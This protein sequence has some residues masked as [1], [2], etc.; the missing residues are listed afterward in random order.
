MT[1]VVSRMIE[2]CAFRI[3]P[4]GSRYLL[5]KRADDEPVYPG[6]WQIV[7][8][9][10]DDGESALAGSLRELR[11]E[12]GLVPLQY[13]AV[14]HTSMFYDHRN[15]AVQILP[16]F[17]ARV[18]S[19]AAVRLSTEHSEFSWVEYAEARSRIVWP[20]QKA[21]LDMVEQVIVGGEAAAG[22][23]EIPL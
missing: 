14:P 23:S 13:W 18:S 10:L 20:A 15:D 21:G 1:R 2:V 16:L 22:F 4:E 12:T 11:E 19:E 5:L 7:T 9:A 17:A 8:G 6:M 3:T